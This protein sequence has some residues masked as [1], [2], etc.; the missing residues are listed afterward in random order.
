[1]FLANPRAIKVGE[2]NPFAA[3]TKKSSFR[4]SEDVGFAY[5]YCTPAV[6]GAKPTL[7]MS[8]TST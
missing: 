1:M 5:Q 7:T 8:I 3:A 2:P 4:K 6:G